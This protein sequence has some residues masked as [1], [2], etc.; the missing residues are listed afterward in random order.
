LRRAM[1]SLFDDLPMFAGAAPGSGS[2]SHLPAT[3]LPGEEPDP[4][5]TPP[6]ASDQAG[7]APS[8]TAEELLEG[9]NPQQRAAVEHI[10]GQLLIIAGAGSISS[11]PPICSTAARCWG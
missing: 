9:L 2:N 11:C 10:G 7:T 4:S 3:M 8:D 1:T 6:H 5:T